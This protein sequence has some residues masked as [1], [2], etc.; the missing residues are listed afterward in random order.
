[1]HTSSS[2]PLASI[3]DRVDAQMDRIRYNNPTLARGKQIAFAMVEAAL[4]NEAHSV[5]YMIGKAVKDMR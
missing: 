2:I 3:S 1:M 5:A 4:G